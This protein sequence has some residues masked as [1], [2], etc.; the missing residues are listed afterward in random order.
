MA[1]IEYH[2]KICSKYFDVK[3]IISKNF[4]L[5]W[6]RSYYKA[7]QKCYSLIHDDR[8]IHMWFSQWWI[9]KKEDLKTPLQYVKKYITAE[10]KHVLELACWR[11]ANSE[12]LYSHYPSI[13]YYWLDLSKDQLSYAKASTSKIEYR[14][15]DYHNLSTFKRE[16]MNI[17]FVIEALCYSEKKDMVCE[18]VKRVLKPGGKFIVIDGYTRDSLKNLSKEKKLAVLLTAKSMWIDKVESYKKF[19]SYAKSSW[20]KLIEERDKSLSVLPSM[21]RL[22]HRTARMT[23]RKRLSWLLFKT[24]PDL[25]KNNYVAAQLM[26]ELIRSKTT[27]YMVSVF[28]K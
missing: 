23:K 4:W 11:W 9:F 26:P 2:L 22:K 8:F 12:Y 27:C 20:L 5:S 15:W 17:V 18:E 1:W 19:K 24:M 25:I 7:N 16:S 3:K 10:T 6:I 13:S 21:E 14:L 28:E